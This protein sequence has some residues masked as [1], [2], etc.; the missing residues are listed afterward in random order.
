MWRSNCAVERRHHFRLWK[1]LAALGTSI[2]V[3]A[4]L[5]SHPREQRLVAAVFALTVVLWATET[6]PIGVTSLGAMAMLSLAAGVPETEAFSGLGSPIIPLFIGSLILAKAMEVTGLSKR[7]ALLV[8]KREWPTRTPGHLM[9]TLCLFTGTVS[10]FLSNTA[11]TAMMMPIALSILIAL[12]AKSSRAPYAIGLLLALTFSANVSVGTPI[13]TPPD[14]LAVQQVQE[15]AHRDL[16]FGLW[17]SFGIPITA[18]LI[19]AVWAVLMLLFGR[20][21]PDTRKAQQETA[22]EL[23]SLPPMSSA[24]KMVGWTLLASVILWLSPAFMAPLLQGI[25]PRLSEWITTRL[26]AN[27]VGV[28]AA[29]LLF[30]LPSRESEGGH[31]ITWRDAA[32]IDWG[33]VLLIAAG[34][35]LGEALFKCGLARELGMD[36]AQMTGANSLWS[37]TALGI[38]MA[39]LISEFAS[40]TATAT[41]LLPVM[42]GLAQGAGVSPVAPALGTALGASMGFMLP[43][44]T[45]TNALV[46]STGIIPQA[47]M[48]KAALVLDFVAFFV[49]FGCLRLILPIVGLA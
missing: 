3:Y 30:W 4:L 31:P 37:I 29:L 33:I 45:A 43:F 17:M 32:S 8:L 41:A 10:L 22:Q 14:L 34:I 28:I 35:S 42:I 15:A 2:L 47:Q 27:I 7:V 13:G 6:F 39:I 38:A 11:T 16:T 49:I 36:I 19:L 25:L 20:K 40:N 1:P 18:M 5:Q 46:Y 48:M 44:S 24:E 23:Q 9:L 26:S 12:D 21:A